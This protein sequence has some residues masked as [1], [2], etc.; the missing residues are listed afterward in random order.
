MEIF[1]NIILMVHVVAAFVIIGLVLIQHGKGAE[2]GASFG[3]GSAG[4]LFGATGSANFLSRAT[5][6]LAT[7]FFLTSLGLAYI[8]THKPKSAG[9]GVMDGV[10]APAKPAAPAVP[11]T[12]PGAI[13]GATPGAAAP[14]APAQ[15]A[16]ANPTS[17]AAIPGAATAPAAA[18]ASAPATVPAQKA[19]PAAPASPAESGKSSQS[20]K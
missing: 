17:P 2:I 18:P 3:G 1:F 4:S 13:P 16:P 6:I 19:A 20:P 8:A 15:S 5:A 9:G 14:A 10:T 12:S 7:L 11:P